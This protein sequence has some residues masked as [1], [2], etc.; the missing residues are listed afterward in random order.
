MFL[1]AVASGDG[2]AASAPHR[3]SGHRLASALH[4][5]LV[6]RIYDRN[7]EIISE[8]L[9]RAPH[10]PSAVRNPGQSSKRFH[11]HGRPIL[12]PA[13]GYELKGIARALIADLRHGR[14]VEGGSTITQ[15]LS[16]VLFLFAEKNVH[17]QTARIAAGPST[18]AQLFKEEIFQMYMNQIYFGHGAYGVEAAA[19][20][21]FGKTRARPQFGRMC[22][23]GGASAVAQN[24]FAVL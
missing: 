14:V 9:H 20:T 11:G 22:A 2:G 13:L 18:R 12:L 1:V 3:S 15:Q 24:V 21:L 19:R 7:N 10:R 17:A 5:A 6:T 23:A 16:K 4:A 8:L